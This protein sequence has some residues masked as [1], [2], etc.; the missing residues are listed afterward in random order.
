MADRQYREVVPLDRDQY[1]NFT[2]LC[3]DLAQVMLASVSIP[4]FVDNANILL[5]CLGLA[6]AVCA[7]ALSFIPYSLHD[8][9]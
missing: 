8:D 5:A 1:E 9:V 3:R 6:A 2:A 4:L 7:A